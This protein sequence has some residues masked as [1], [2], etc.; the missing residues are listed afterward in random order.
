MT[1]KH[2]AYEAYEIDIAGGEARPRRV[3][4]AGERWE[5]DSSEER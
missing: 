5:R 4:L 2:L 3:W 1:G